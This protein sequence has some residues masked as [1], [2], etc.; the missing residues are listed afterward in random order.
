[1][2]KEIFYGDAQTDV[3]RINGKEQSIKAR[4]LH[5]EIVIW[6]LNEDGNPVKDN[7][8]NVKTKT[9]SECISKI[10]ITIDDDYESE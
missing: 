10:R 6:D 4:H 1:M 2:T 7:D 3:V 8:G 9:I 5:P